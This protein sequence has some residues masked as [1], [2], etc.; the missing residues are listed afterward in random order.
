MYILG[1]GGDLMSRATL[2]KINKPVES[3]N[4][5]NNHFALELTTIFRFQVFIF[6]FLNIILT[7]RFSRGK[8]T[9]TKLRCIG[10]LAV[11]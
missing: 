7:S 2:V 4:S 8:P 3:G 1:G 5:G 11:I 10:T 6:I 9:N